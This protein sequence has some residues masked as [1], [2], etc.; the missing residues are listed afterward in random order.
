MR[1]RLWHSAGLALY[2]AAVVVC[3]G[4]HLTQHADLVAAH[5][6]DSGDDEHSVAADLVALGLEDV[7]A[8][9]RVDCSL[10]ALTL[11]DCEAPAHGVR[12]FGDAQRTLPDGHRPTH[13]SH[14][15]GGDAL[16]HL[17]ASLLAVRAFV[18]PPPRCRETRRERAQR[19]VAV[20]VAFRRSYESRGPPAG[21]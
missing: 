20:S 7:G 5:A 6:H 3:P 10:A 9:S 16:E 12:R 8:P 19:P 11:V 13:S 21:V 4:L 18:L 2:L 15:H 14:R 17:A 1:H